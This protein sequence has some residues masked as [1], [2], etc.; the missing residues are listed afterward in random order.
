MAAVEGWSLR[1]ARLKEINEDF[2]S[3]VQRFFI[4]WASEDMFP[5]RAFKW[6]IVKLFNALI[7]RIIA[8]QGRELHISPTCA[9][10]LNNV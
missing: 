10:E 9:W 8:Y 7:W 2:L 6:L 5:S 3:R 4:A 1:G